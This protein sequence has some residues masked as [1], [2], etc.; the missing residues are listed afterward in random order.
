MHR[1]FSG[2]NG[3]LAQSAIRTAAAAQMPVTVLFGQSPAGLNATGEKATPME[4]AELRAGQA[5]IDSAYVS[6][7]VLS[8]DEVAVSRFASEG[9]SAETQIDLERGD[10]RSRGEHPR[11]AHEGAIAKPAWRGRR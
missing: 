6:A 5:Q 8:A 1:Q 11:K 9:W 4:E 2:L 7:N 10:R 3:L